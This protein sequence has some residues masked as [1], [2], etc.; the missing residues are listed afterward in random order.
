MS[1]PALPR[2]PLGLGEDELAARFAELQEKLVPQWQFMNRLHASPYTTVVVPS[3]SLDV[4]F[5]ATV[6]RAYEE[7]LLFLLLLL[8]QPRARIV[9]VTSLPIHPDIVDY[10]LA[11]LPGVIP[12]HARKRLVTI[13]AHDASSRPL[14]EKLLVRPRLLE[15]VREAAGDPD[16]AHLAPFMTTEL[17]RELALRLG[18]PMYGAD[19]KFWAYGTK[20][21]GR[22]LFAAV[23]VPHPAGAEDLRS[24]ADLT[25]AL[26]DLRAARPTLTEALVKLDEG[27]SGEGNARVDLS[28]LPEPGTGGERAA[29]TERLRALRCEREDLSAAA[30]LD[31]A[32]AGGA[33]I[34]ER[35][36]GEEFT[37]PSVQ[38]RVSPLGEVQ[39]LSTHDQLL[40]GPS[41]QAFLGCVFPAAPSYAPAIAELAA[42]VGKRLADEGVI[43]RFAVDFVVVRDRSGAWQPYAIEVNLR[44]GGTTHPFLTLEFLTGGRYDPAAAR[45]VAPSGSAK[46]Y[47]ASD[48]FEADVFRALDVDDLFDFAIRHRLHFDQS[49]Q[50]GIVYHMLSSVTEFGRFGVTAVGDSHHQARAL[51]DQAVAGLEREAKAAL[52]AK[53]L[54]AL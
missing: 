12:S 30:F 21:G 5:P 4:D 11:L 10:Y 26:A 37:S 29:L 3:V 20:S 36:R 43:G 15:R 45:F 50:T 14:T 18:I 39:L 44:K 19:P 32:A 24:V 33:V 28:D 31:Q 6:L 8:R 41:G 52:V 2:P 35:I 23:G 49:T 42:Q 1:G 9:Y 48:H 46:C 22:K 54:S 40:G 53:P 47:V 34:E 38:L 27:V 51:Y 7:R 13:A 25:A 17:E 16:S